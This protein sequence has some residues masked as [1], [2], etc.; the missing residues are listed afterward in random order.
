MAASM[1]PSPPA[2]A[3]C[4]ANTDRIGMILDPFDRCLAHLND[5]ECVDALAQFEPGT[6]LNLRETALSSTLLG[7]LGIGQY[8]AAGL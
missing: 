2:W 4:D 8:R 1:T 5:E 7:A 6:D 3:T